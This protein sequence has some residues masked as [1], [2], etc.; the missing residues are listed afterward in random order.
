MSDI[1]TKGKD[2][3]EPKLENIKEQFVPLKIWASF[4]LYFFN[5]L[6]VS[7]HKPNSKLGFAGWEYVKEV[8]CGKGRC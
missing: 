8:A 1:K 2:Y 4:K 6:N 3:V 7:I 5:L